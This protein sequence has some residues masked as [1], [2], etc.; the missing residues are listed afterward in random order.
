[1]KITEDVRKYAAERGLS[2]DEAF[3]PAWR[4]SLPSLWNAEPKFI[5]KR[6]LSRSSARAF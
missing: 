3:G 5:P 6:E 2:E 4:K 1:M